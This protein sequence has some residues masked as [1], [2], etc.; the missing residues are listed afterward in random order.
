MTRLQPRPARPGAAVP[1]TTKPVWLVIGVLGMSGIVTSSQQ[2]LLLPLLS[3]F[4]GILDASIAE[5]S[6]LVTAT[7]LAAAVATPVLSRLADMHGKRRMVIVSLAA[8]VVGSVLG[9][10]A[11]EL[12]LLVVAR[13][14]AGIGMAVVPLGISIMRDE[15]PPERVG[16]GIAVMSA[17]FGIGSGLG[18]PLS[19]VI[20]AGLGW[21]AVFW[22]TAIIAVVM[23]A[24]VALVIRPSTIR[25]GGRFDVVGALVLSVSLVTL[26]LAITNGGVW[27]WTSPATVSCIVIAV[28]SFGLWIPLE[29]RQRT[30][31]VDLRVSTRR[32]VLMTNIATTVLGFAIFANM[33]GSTQQVQIPVETGYGLGLD[34]TG[35]GLIMVPGSLC[36]LV[37]A[38]LSGWALNRFGGRTVLVAGAVI[39][40][41]AYGYRL[42]FDDELWQVV[43]A[44]TVIAFGTTLVVAAGPWIIMRN[45]PMTETAAANGLN[46]L[47]R[48]VGTAASAAIVTA[49]LAVTA[50]R[51][52]GTMTPAEESFH[53]LWIIAIVVCLIGAVAG[54]ASGR[55]RLPT[56][57]D[58]VA[59]PPRSTDTG[60]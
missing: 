33:I 13:G 55:D 19:G 32:P 31:M 15:L 18:F 6:W 45:S 20:V 23:L 56:D 60:G 48:S 9:G 39:M 26:L 24:L 14:I 21:H 49:V 17:S 59:E 38:P 58:R 57:Y 34:P 28:V 1:R 41:V 36:L 10:V 47:L 27:G 4:P 51:V 54:A 3:I 43:L 29:L 35:A 8:I 53:Q 22:I 44:V 11:E 40:G 42:A 16:V 12:P 7:L 52:A 37:F 2:T 46:A 30:P 5:V 50:V 25:T